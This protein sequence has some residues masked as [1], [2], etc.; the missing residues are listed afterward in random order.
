M[1]RTLI[2][3]VPRDS[4]VAQKGSTS[5]SPA[6]ARP[7]VIPSRRLGNLVP[8][9]CSVIRPALSGSTVTVGGAWR[10]KPSTSRSFRLLGSEHVRH[11]RGRNVSAAPLMP[12][13]STGAAVTL[14]RAVGAGGFEPP[15]AEPAVLQTAPFGRSGTLP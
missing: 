6:I 5:Q 2:K 12:H 13:L 11:A 4:S 3:G 15:K 7:D 9:R 8:M 10:R 1:D 14:N